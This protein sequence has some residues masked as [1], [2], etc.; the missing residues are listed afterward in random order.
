MNLPSR[1]SSDINKLKQKRDSILREYNALKEKLV[2]YFRMYP[3]PLR[4]KC[5]YDYFLE[6]SVL[7]AND[8][9]E[10]RKWKIQVAYILAHEAQAFFYRFI[11]PNRNSQSMKPLALPSFT[12]EIEV[13][14][15]EVEE[16][17]EKERELLRQQEENQDEDR[18]R[19]ICKII[20]GMV[21]Q[22]WERVHDAHTESLEVP[23]VKQEPITPSLQRYVKSVYNRGTQGGPCVNNE[24][25]SISDLY[26]Q[27]PMKLPSYIAY[28]ASHNLACVVSCLQGG[29]TLENCILQ[30]IGELDKVD[31]GFILVPESWGFLEFL[32]IRR[33]AEMVGF[34]ASIRLPH[35]SLI[36]ERRETVVL[37]Q[38][39]RFQSQPQSRGCLV[40]GSAIEAASSEAEHVLSQCSVHL[41]LLDSAQRLSASFESLILAQSFD[42]GHQTHEL[43]LQATFSVMGPSAHYS[44]T[45][46][47]RL[48]RDLGE[49]GNALLPLE[50]E[51]VAWTDWQRRLCD[52]LLGAV[53]EVLDMHSAQGSTVSTVS[54]IG[55]GGNGSNSSNGSASSAPNSA[56]PS[57]STVSPMSGSGV[58]TGD[59]SSEVL[60]AFY[61]LHSRVELPFEAFGESSCFLPALQYLL[62]TPLTPRIAWPRWL[63]SV[64]YRSPYEAV[65]TTIPNIRNYATLRLRQIEVK[66][67]LESPHTRICFRHSLDLPEVPIPSKL[68]GLRDLSS[69]SP[70]LEIPAGFQ[71]PAAV[72]ELSSPRVATC[73][74]QLVGSS[75]RYKWL[76]HSEESQK[77]AQFWALKRLR[78]AS[79]VPHRN[80]TP[81]LVSGRVRRVL[82]LLG[83]GR[84]KRAKQLVIVDSEAMAVSIAGQLRKQG[85]R[86]VVLTGDPTN[87]NPC[88]F[89]NH[90][91]CVEFNHSSSATIA[92]LCL[93][94]FAESPSA[95]A[96]ETGTQCYAAPI[97]Q[98]VIVAEKPRPGYWDTLYHNV[99]FMLGTKRNASATVKE[100]FSELET[101]ISFSER[102]ERNDR[103]ALHDA[104]RV[105]FALGT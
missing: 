76:V 29:F 15:E 53:K 3:E 90:R 62:Q 2:P 34:L 73:S 48:E 1:L 6:E 89:W 68:H 25:P 13:K 47:H 21:T 58:G 85:L 30:L 88:S 46:Q 43:F 16:D 104:K 49:G 92:L 32:M 103:K 51:T 5:H 55:N 91:R 100:V 27:K 63:W 97:V 45:R 8:F 61:L 28:C 4:R 74:P 70:L 98:Q 59:V 81:V 101:R 41:C 80:E 24:T 18:H 54:T 99:L 105:L 75:Y 78:P 20:A 65:L 26:A 71:L 93:R 86:V 56:V 87:S 42:S 64:L 9:L 60:Y 10:E 67:L 39:H 79:S 44:S 72:W 83:E 94:C 7:M 77:E 36:T 69:V 11:E 66:L 14:K 40:L 102:K 23:A 35:H 31:E 33:M 96:N 37:Y 19:Q 50:L 22:F 95:A 38:V 82:Q 84:A 52:G 12:G 17:R 57:V